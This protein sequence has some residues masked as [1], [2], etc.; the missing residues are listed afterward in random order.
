MK[1]AYYLLMLITLLLNSCH[2]S[3]IQNG[4][5]ALSYKYINPSISPTNGINR[6]KV[7]IQNKKVLQ[8]VDLKEGKLIEPSQAYG[9]DYV[10]QYITKDKK[11]LPLNKPIKIKPSNQSFVIYIDNIKR[12]KNNYTLNPL[13]EKKEEL[14][15]NYYNWSRK[16]INYYK[17]RVQDSRFS[18]TYLEGVEL[19]VKN[20]RIIDAIDV[21]NYTKIDTNNRYFLTIKKLFGVAIWDIKDAVID[22]DLNYYYPTLIKLGNGITITSYYLHPLK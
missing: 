18:N 15:K 9:L 11:A 3:Y 8:V 10:M 2:A 6:Y 7:L 12:V 4:K 17:F 13:V 21:R 1:R 14:L 22:Y 20:G 16:N 5:Y 19:T